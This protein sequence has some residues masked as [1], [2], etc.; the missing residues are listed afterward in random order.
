MC[1]RTSV[2][3][4]ALLIYIYIKLSILRKITILSKFLDVAARHVVSLTKNRMKIE[5][6]STK[7]I[8]GNVCK[9]DFRY[10]K[11]VY[12]LVASLSHHCRICIAFMPKKHDNVF[13]KLQSND[14]LR[15]ENLKIYTFKTPSFKSK[16]FSSSI[17]LSE[18]SP[19]SE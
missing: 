8:D 7:S 12:K 14:I 2:I 4:S 18:N 1:F 16:I 10:W 11:P 15:C 17:S 9:T 6:F 13:C 3:L 19:Y 5:T